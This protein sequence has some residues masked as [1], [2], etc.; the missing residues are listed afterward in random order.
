MDAQCRFAPGRA[1]GP[2]AH[3]TPSPRPMR[4]PCGQKLS[5][6]GTPDAVPGSPSPS[7]PD[8]GS[9]DTARGGGG[10]GQPAT[11]QAARQRASEPGRAR[12][13]GAPGQVPETGTGEEEGPHP[14]TPSTARCAGAHAVPGA[15][16][17]GPRT[18]GGAEG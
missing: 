13:A 3:T 4:S 16:V 18:R 7:P 14:G 12:G 8:L 11:Q 6:D 15:R 10:P 9:A 1:Q 17:R 2:C 5:G